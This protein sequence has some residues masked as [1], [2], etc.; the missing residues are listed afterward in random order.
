MVKIAG[1]NWMRMQLNAAQVHDP[2]EPRDVI[3][4][5][6]LRGSPRR[7]GKSH[8]PQPRW[9]LL[10]RA[11]LIEG[12]PRSAIH[13]PLENNGPILDSVQRSRRNRKVIA[14]EFQFR[15]SSLRREVQLAWIRDLNVTPLKHKN[16]FRRFFPHEE[17]LTC[18]VGSGP[19]ASFR[20]FR[21]SPM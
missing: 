6:F 21:P 4:D 8:C 12:F 11:L 16:F 20:V 7:K 3:D 18:S 5:N 10:R 19:P 14:H 1:A 9:T 2:G 17:R 13:E 15:N